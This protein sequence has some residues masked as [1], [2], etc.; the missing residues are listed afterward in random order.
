M[1]IE[2]TNRRASLHV[3]LLYGLLGV[4]KSKYEILPDYNKSVEAVY[5]EVSK[6]FLSA[7]P[8]YLSFWIFIYAPLKNRYTSMPS[9]A[10][11]W[12]TLEISEY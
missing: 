11:D 10:V 9:W 1:R 6:D 4:T 12:T 8:M 7:F 3:D 5:T 2:Y